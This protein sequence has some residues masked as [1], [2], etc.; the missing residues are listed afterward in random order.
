MGMPEVDTLPKLFVLNSQEC[1]DRVAIRRKLYGIWRE[2]TWEDCYSR[3][4]YLSL[5]LISMGLEAGDRV[6]IISDDRPEAYWVE[7]AVGAAS[8]VMVGV[9][10]DSTPSEAKYIIDHSGS[11]FAVAEDQE[12]I[13]KVLEI[14][15]ELPNLRRVIYWDGK[16][17]RKYQ[18]PLLVSF[19][20]VIELGK[21]YEGAHP[22]IFEDNIA[23]GK[24]SDLA[25]I[26]YT[27]GTSGLPKAA[28]LNH[29]L[30]LNCAHAMSEAFAVDATDDLF[31]QI[32]PAHAFQFW[33]STMAS[34][35]KA[36]VN[37]A[38]EPE[39]VMTDYRQISPKFLFLPPRQ[40]ESLASMVQVKTSDAGYLKRTCYRLFSPIGHKLADLTFS[41]EEA[42]PFWKILSTL[43][44]IAVF[45]PLKDKLGLS[46]TEYLLT[47]SSFTSPEIVRL[48]HSMGVKTQVGY[49]S[50][51]GGWTSTHRPDDIN[52]DT[53][54]SMHTWA[55]VRISDEGEIL[56]SGD[57]VFSG[58]YKD[59]ERTKEVLRGRWFH[60]GDAGHIGE[61]GHLVFMDRLSDLSELRSGN[62]YSPAYIESKLR[63]SPYIKDIVLLGGEERDYLAAIVGIDFEAVSKWAEAHK[64]LYTTFVDLSQ[65]SEVAALIQSHIE[66]VNR[67]LP[68]ATRIRKCVLLHKEF[69][70]DE[71]ELTRTRKLRRRAIEE[72]YHDLIAAMYQD[73]EEVW[74]EAQVKY[75]DGREGTVNTALKV[76]S[77]DQ[78]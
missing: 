60:T 38:E 6:S 17:L 54:G 72:R 25:L 41:R 10:S 77:L 28:M 35:K 27:S 33:F 30:M 44:H 67:V 3:V 31:S 26:A 19:D 55:E 48:F 20:E 58:Y 57:A 15:D 68:L 52:M 63:F 16:G 40:L 5:G 76:R 13:D 45:G 62:K 34:C 8:G 39:T 66:R 49:A 36:V 46:K 18:S 9:Y 75:R 56:I 59:Q 37:F 47:G 51:E 1:G 22:S 64:I 2:Y 70:P 71:A 12:Q 7:I 23:G 42:G 73:R 69:D 53:V 74:V 29:R 50:T 4:K 78:D 43:S 11:K 32:P 14:A 21:D 61:D 65:K 24:S